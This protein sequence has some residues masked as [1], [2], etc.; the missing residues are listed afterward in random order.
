MIRLPSAAILLSPWLDL[1]CE[2]SS[3]KDNG[4]FDWLP[5]KARH[6]H[7]NFNP[8]IKSPSYNYVFGYH[9]DRKF[10]VPVAKLFSPFSQAINSFSGNSTRDSRGILYAES[11]DILNWM[12]KHPL[13][14]PLYADLTGLPPIL[15]QVGEAELLFDDGIAFTDKFRLQNIKNPS[16][17]IRLEI[18]TDMVHMFQAMSFMTISKFAISNVSHY[19]K[20]LE[21]QVH[22]ER[23][24]TKDEIKMLKVLAHGKQ[25]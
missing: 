24:F 19:I 4:N 20:N 7:E 2:A 9:P 25:V 14:S 18:Y 22:L 23:D 21:R 10:A 1:S 11:R 3:W 12:L 13:V 17:C 6:V 8:R 5:S 16:S 15:V